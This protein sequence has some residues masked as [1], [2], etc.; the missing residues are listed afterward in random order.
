MRVVTSPRGARLVH[1]GHTVS[2]LPARPGPTKSIFDVLAALVAQ[3]A[4]VRAPVAMLGFAAGGTVAP[5]RALGVAGRIDAVDLSSDGVAAFRRI[6]RDWA[7]EVDIAEDEASRWLRSRRVR[8]G[9]VIDDLSMQV[10]GDVTKPEVSWTVL[11]P[12]MASRLRG[13]GVTAHNLLPVAG[14]SWRSLI[15][16]VTRDRPAAAEVRSRDYDNRIVITADTLPP[17]NALR[18]EL[19]ARLDSIASPLAV[20]LSVRTLAR[21]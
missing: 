2:V 11:P 18:R 12:L 7:G 13:G 5:L 3:L 16:Q 10:P 8:Y 4:P 20:G 21:P 1:D 6:A 15:E 17:A 14:L 19:V 9:A